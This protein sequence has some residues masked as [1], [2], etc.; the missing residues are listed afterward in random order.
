W[1]H[2]YI[3]RVSG[4]ALDQPLTFGDLEGV[5]LDEAEGIQGI[6]LR[7]MT[8]ALSLGRPYSLPL[9]TNE[10]Y[11]REAELALYFPPAIIAWMKAN[12]GQR[13][14]PQRDKALEAMGYR[15]LPTHETLPVAVAT[16]MSLSFPGLLSAVP[17]YRD[18]WEERAPKAKTMAPDEE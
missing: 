2:R 3:Q 14:N 18:A 11:F 1:F 8:T 6:R 4:K 17:L 7:M 5:T 15:P 10:F 12:P 9:S 16:R 13:T